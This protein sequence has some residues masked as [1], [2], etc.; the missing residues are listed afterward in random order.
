[1]GP[2]G[3][4]RGGGPARLAGPA[5][6]LAG[7]GRAGWPSCGPSWPPRAS[8][9]SCSAAWAGRRWRRRSSAARRACRWSCSTPPTPARSPRAMTDLDRTVVVVSSKSGGTVETDSQRRAF[10]TR[11]RRR[12]AWTRRRSA[13]ASSSS[14]TPAPRCRRPPRRW[15]PGRCSSPTRP[16]AAATARCRR[17]AWCPPPWPAPTSARCS[18]RPRS[19]PSTWPSRTTP[20]LELGAALGAAFRGGPRQAGP[21]RRRL[22]HH[23]L[24]RLGRAADRRVHRQGGPRD[25]ARR[26]RVR[27]RPRLLRR[28]RRCSPSSVRGTPAARPSL[29]VDGPA[30][31]AVP[32]L[33]VRH[34]RRRPGP[35]D[36]PLRPAERHREQGEHQRILAEGLP[37]ERPAATI[38]AIE[39]RGSGGVLDGVDL[40]SHDGVRLALDALLALDPAARLPRRHGLP[41]PRAG[42]RAPSASGP[43]SPAAPSTPSPSGGA[44]LPALHRPVPQ[45][46]PAG[47]RV[48]AAHRRGGRGSAGARPAVHLRHPAGRPGRRRPQGPRRPVPARCCT[49]T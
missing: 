25:P 21:R 45:G 43:R 48:P 10:I 33:G 49:C 14:P 18:T 37:D 15:A 22:G 39:V 47:R 24:R 31:G 35:G 17:S 27:R 4:E 42:R 30:R 1:M 46:R 23:R 6:E 28:R 20:P 41:G 13:R 11:V 38:G 16:S 3:R 5:G 34:R 40:S 32:R 9:G 12:P 29:G 2:R 44:P 36:Q 19:W 8:T 26:P 7:A